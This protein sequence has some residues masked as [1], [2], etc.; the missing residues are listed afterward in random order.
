[1][2]HI[3]GQDHEMVGNGSPA[4]PFYQIQVV[5]PNMLLGFVKQ[6]ANLREGTVYN[7]NRP[8]FINIFQLV[9][10]S[11]SYVIPA[12]SYII[13]TRYGVPYIPVPYIPVP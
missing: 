7:D 1:M 2:E 4:P 11:D 3:N 6:S 10:F 13:V 5:S 9:F 8:S 12:D